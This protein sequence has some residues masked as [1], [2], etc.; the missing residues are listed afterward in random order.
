MPSDLPSDP[1]SEP[2]RIRHRY[3]PLSVLVVDDDFRVAELHADQVRRLDGFT[4]A[5]T[6]R[7]GAETARRLADRTPGRDQQPVDLVLLDSYLPDGSGIELLGS[8]AVRQSHADIIMVTADNAGSSVRRALQL[9]AINYLVKPFEPQRLAE[10]L[11]AYRGYRRALAGEHCDQNLIDRSLRALL[12][13][14]RTAS[15]RGH[16]S[17]TVSR[18]VDLLATQAADLSATE[19]AERAGIARATAQRYLAQLAEDGTA[20]V[21]LRYGSTGR[22]EHRYRLRTDHS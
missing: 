18:I 6:A 15:V 20:E 4:V 2:S 3:R 10:V 7:S 1:P 17:L 9:G 16:S 19:V 12:D 8:P 22:P 13:G 5:G 14:N 11:I 21:F